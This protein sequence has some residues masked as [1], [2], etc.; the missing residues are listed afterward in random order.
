MLLRQKYQDL[1][2]VHSNLSAKTKT[3]FDSLTSS[4]Q[5]QERQQRVVERQREGQQGQNPPLSWVN[6]TDI[7]RVAFTRVGPKS[8]K[9]DC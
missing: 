3:T 1:S 4:S 5:G 7:F 6:F 2:F 8:I 9:S